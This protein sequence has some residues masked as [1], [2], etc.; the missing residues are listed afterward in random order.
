MRFSHRAQKLAL[1]GFLFAVL[2]SSAFAEDS[3]ESPS[4]PAFSWD[5]LLW[6]QVEISPL[7][8]LESAPPSSEK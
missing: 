8:N 7:P 5:T 2:A 1:P 4:I 6:K 3:S